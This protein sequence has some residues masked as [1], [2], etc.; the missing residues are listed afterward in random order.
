MI[1]KCPY[2]GGP[3]S[4]VGIATELW[5]GRSGVRIPEGRDFPSIQT[6]PGAHPASCTMGTGSFRGVN[7]GR[8]VLLTTN[9]LLVPRSWKSRAILL[10]TLWATTGPV[11]G[12]VYL[13]SISQMFAFT[14]LTEASRLHF[15]EYILSLIILFLG[16]VRRPSF[17]VNGGQATFNV[18]SAP[19]CALPAVKRIS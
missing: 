11:K 5:S 4:S 10:P 19:S 6:G 17:N 14:A 18:S 12:T 9:P 13:T 1:R 3:G 15:P 16:K 7:Y 2:E 8:G